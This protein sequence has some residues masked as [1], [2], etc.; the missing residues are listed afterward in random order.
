[1][2]SLIFIIYVSFGWSTHNIVALFFILI[3][4]NENNNIYL[5]E[6]Y[7]FKNL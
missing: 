7:H 4:V 5:E 1:M 3:V 2:Y 6:N